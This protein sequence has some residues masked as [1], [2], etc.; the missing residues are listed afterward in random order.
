M[1]IDHH[2]G[3]VPQTM[4]ELVALPGIGRKTANV[5][6][7]AAFGKT[8]GIA[9]DTHVMRLSQRL[10]L[11]RARDP[12][13]IELDLIAQTPREEWGT[14]TTHLISHCRAVCSALNRK[15]EQCVFKKECPSSLVLGKPDLGR[16]AP[17]HGERSRTTGRLYKTS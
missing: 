15:C 3:R 6:L 16:D 9:V 7:S 12:K 11:T 1:L 13:K 14:L 8:E 5:I 17:C 2:T 10:G 4:E